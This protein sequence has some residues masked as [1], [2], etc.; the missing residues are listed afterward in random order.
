MTTSNK[1]VG[2]THQSSINLPVGKHAHYKI[3]YEYGGARVTNEGERKW[4]LTLIEILE[5]FE[6]G[7][8]LDLKELRKHFT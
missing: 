8:E 7:T 1:I 3:P 6:I 5:R 4:R 2:S